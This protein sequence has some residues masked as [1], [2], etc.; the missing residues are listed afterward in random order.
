MSE[1]YAVPDQKR[2]AEADPGLPS[3]WE[4]SRIIRDM[5]LMRAKRP[6]QSRGEWDLLEVVKTIPGDE[7]FRPAAESEC[8]A[9]RPG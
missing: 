3:P 2:L 8:P 1:L 4:C 6:D 5:Y 9:L 7:A